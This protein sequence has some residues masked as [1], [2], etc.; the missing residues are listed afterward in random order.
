MTTTPPDDRPDLP[1]E[2]TMP[3][4][5]RKDTLAAS[6]GTDFRHG[7]FEP[8]QRLGSRYRIVALLG[9]GGMGEVY[10]A[11]DLE[12][13]QSVAL[14]FLPERVAADE[15]WLRRFR[16]EVRTARQIAHP[17]VCRIYDI[18]Q[19]DGHVFLSME[20]V[21]GEDLAGVL[22]RLGR[23]SREKAIEIAR[24]IC[25]GLA[26]A[27][28][29]KVLHRDLKPANIMID[30]R[31]RV[32]IT[33]FGLAGFLDELEGIEARAGTPAYMAP[34]Q[35]TN[36]TVSVRS[37]VYS[38]GLILHELFTGKS[39]FDTNDIEE[40]KRKHTSGSASTPST[41]TEDIDPA[42]ERM[43]TRCLETEPAQ[44]PQS[45]YQVLAALPGGDP[46][47]AALAAGETPSPEMVANVR[48]EGG[49]RPAVAIGLAVTMLVTVAINYVITAT[50]V[51]MPD[52]S[53]ER[54]SV[55]AEQVLE[56]LGFSDLPRFSVSGYD[57]NLSF[58]QSLRDHPKTSQELEHVEWPPR[59]RYW[60]RWSAGDFLAPNLHS[61][62][63]RMIDSPTDW[64]D[65]TMTVALDSRGRL[66]GLA[67]PPSM[68][69]QS[70]V[71]TDEVDWALLFDRAGLDPSDAIRIEP[72]AAPTNYCDTIVAWQFDSSPGRR[73]PVTVL[74]GAFKGHPNYFEI[75][76]LQDGMVPNHRMF[77]QSATHGVLPFIGRLGQQ[78]LPKFFLLFAI[79]LAARNVRAGRV[80]RRN[81]LRC[82]LLVG[83]LYACLE[84][85]SITLG[86]SD[87]VGRLA[88]LLGGPAAGHIL[89]H[90]IEAWL[91]Y[92][93][94]EPYV[95]RVWPR[96]LI[97]LVRALSGRWRDPAVGREVLVGLVT[98]CV[99]VLVLRLV[100]SAHWALTAGG[101]ARL[102][103]ALSL[104]SIQSPEHFMANRAHMIA[105]AVLAG[106]LMAGVMVLTR[107]LVRHA[108]ASLLL[109]M[110]I[111][112]LAQSWVYHFLGGDSTW[113]A[114]V[115]AIGI[116]ACFAWLLTRVGVLSAMTY[117]F[118]VLSMSFS[119]LAFDAWSTPYL[120]TWSAILFVLGAYGFWMS[121]AGQPIFKD[122][123]AEPQPA[124]R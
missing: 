68:V 79:I 25:L 110:A 9:E 44:R 88:A 113:G 8:G 32:R 89:I 65:R 24:Q 99:F 42:V 70:G 36:G 103:Q 5:A 30:G 82:A 69:A 94:I 76:G 92:L 117:F 123:L 109:G 45:V 59:Y 57:L 101:S 120:L 84:I 17:N 48:D 78:Y 63:H 100:S 46:L 15:S 122:M 58:A 112:A 23:P 39:V 107:V 56:D 21:D 93:A 6:G 33:D 26:A 86:G 111:M 19:A 35:L 102:A 61:S 106:I 121:L 105:W 18:G 27:H 119:G 71:P 115:F 91:Y 66:L 74:M 60:R 55:V 95:R 80:D 77:A 4:E 96:M 34:E 10:R 29:S 28:E 14:K 47:A 81:A 73:E 38:M 40:L 7:R 12:L 108:V 13:G 20:Y 11:D 53:P 104:R 67:I 72:G 51:V 85:I 75:V 87:P 62:E 49:L 22:R 3:V 118:I 54:L 1:G 97:G 124:A 2:E 114:L 116:A 83:G 43:I 64:P 41:I 31:G 98:G 37:D 50:T 90:G 52:Q 16:N